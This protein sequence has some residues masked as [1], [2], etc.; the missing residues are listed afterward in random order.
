MK[1]IH[2]QMKKH[3]LSPKSLQWQGNKYFVSWPIRNN[4]MSNND[5]IYFCYV[6]HRKWLEKAAILVFEAGKTK[7]IYFP[8]NVF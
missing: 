2:V 7:L 6:K 3:V 8:K 1:K 5:M 4:K